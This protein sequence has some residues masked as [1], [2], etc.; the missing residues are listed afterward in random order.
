MLPRIDEEITFRK[1]EILLESGA[2]R[3]T[4]L[5]IAIR[6]DPQSVVLGGTPAALEIAEHALAKRHAHYTR[7]WAP[8]EARCVRPR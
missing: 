1:L 4:G 8:R 3:E 7:R 2:G 6:N 5:A